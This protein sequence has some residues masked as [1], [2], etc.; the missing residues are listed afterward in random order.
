MTGPRVLRVAGHIV[1]L[2]VDRD[3]GPMLLELNA[4][5]GLQIQIA[6]GSGLRPRLETI[7][8]L[9]EPPTDPAERIAFSRDRFGAV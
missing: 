9:P 2:V 6:N 4:R 7:E 3:H 5:P 8:E 1:D